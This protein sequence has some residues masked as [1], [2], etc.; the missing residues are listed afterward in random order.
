M[1]GM[2]WTEDEVNLLKL[3]EGKDL[4]FL[5]II[6]PYR[7]KTQISLK[8][9]REN[10]KYKTKNNYWTDEEIDKLKECNGCF[11]DD[12]INLFDNKTR[13]SIKAKA[14]QSGV[15]LITCTSLW[16]KE[17]DEI[18]YN[19]TLGK[20][21]IK[22]LKELIHWRSER[23]IQ[24][25]VF[26]LGLTISDPNYI[27]IANTKKY[28]KETSKIYHYETK[29]GIILDKEKLINTYS[30]IQWWEWTYYKTPNG[31]TLKMMPLEIIQDNKSLIEI[32]RYVIQNVIGYNTREKVLLLDFKTIQK[33]KIK[34]KQLF[35]G[36]LEETLNLIFP[37]YNIKGYELNNV[38]LSYWAS[39]EN[40]DIYMEYILK[41]KLNIYTKQNLRKYIIES[42]DYKTIRKM[43]YGI[44]TYIIYAHK[45]YDSFY[46]WLNTLHP[47]WEL[48]EEDFNEYI[49]FDGAV[50][51]SREEI[52]LYNKIKQDITPSIR[53]IGNNRKNKFNNETYN[54]C[55]IP[56]FIIDG[57]DKPCIIEYFGLY[58]ENPSDNQ[59]LRT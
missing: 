23:A 8:C 31:K 35:K 41:E 22:E 56:D 58:K 7:N 20:K 4:D 37:K 59:Y 52:T 44:L 48:K 32:T 11:V 45:H 14:K 10:I 24:A 21:T 57:I 1:S 54:E 36:S 28:R 19:N 49:G 6:F 30:P 26:K 18:L 29:F 15:Q 3:N 34:F 38:P 9:M 39:K 17:E 53:A 50:L 27:P 16:T 40:C 2:L 55:Y 13:Y 25:R 51:C 42:F 5:V 33:Y 47:E 12:I 46:E 43:G